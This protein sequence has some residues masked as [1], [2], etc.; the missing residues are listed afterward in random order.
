LTGYSSEATDT[1]APLA[2]AF[3]AADPLLGTAW[4]NNQCMAF[5]ASLVTP[6][7][8]SASPAPPQFFNSPQTCTLNCPD[9]T[10]FV[11]EVE[12]GLFSASTQAAADAAANAYACQQAALRSICLS[13]PSPSPALQNTPYTGVITAT[14]GKL[15]GPGQTNNWQ[16]VSGALPPGLT[17]NGGNLPGNTAT[18]TGT[19]T[20]LGT[21][22]FG[23]QVT[24]PEGDTTTQTLS[25]TV[26]CGN[27]YTV[28]R[29]DSNRYAP[30]PADPGYDTKFL[31]G[32]QD[33]EVLTLN[34]VSYAPQ[35]WNFKWNWS[36]GVGNP[37]L[38]INGVNQASLTGT[39]TTGG[40]GNPTVVTLA[41]QGLGQQ[42]QTLYLEWLTP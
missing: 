17:F 14:G 42:A 7:G 3:V 36:G 29:N 5:A 19:P 4:C 2:T 10:P 26:A 39:F 1:L 12:A 24:D 27:S 18:I 22:L 25:L 16:L 20:A 37:T 35:T 34:F 9:G 6:A 11:F 21:F 8:S 30:A 23:V 15:A 31:G 28:T 40:C 32:T 13:G 33:F 41:S 38:T